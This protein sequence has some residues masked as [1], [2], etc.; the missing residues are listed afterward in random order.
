MTQALDMS[1]IHEISESLMRISRLLH[2]HTHKLEVAVEGTYAGQT[3]DPRVSLLMDALLV[4]RKADLELGRNSQA[5]KRLTTQQLSTS[6]GKGNTAATRAVFER[7]RAELQSNITFLK[8]QRD[9]QGILADIA[10]TLNSTLEFD[11]VLRLVMDRVIEFV[12]AERGF[13][14]LVDQQTQDLEF[15]IARDKQ[16]RTIPESEF[17]TAG[18]SRG[19]VKRTITTL[20]PLVSDDA[21]LDASLNGHESIMTFGIRSMMCAPLVV[22]DHCIGAVYVDSRINANLF[23]QQHLDLLVA[24]C[25]QAAIAIDN[26]R[27]FADLNRAIQQV[28]DDKQYMD[29]IFASIA[30]GV[31]TID[32]RGY[33]TTFNASAGLILQINNSQAIGRHYTEAFASHAHIGVV[34][35]LRNALEHAEL[36]AHGTFVPSSVDNCIIPNRLNGPFSLNL[37]VSS[38]RDTQGAHIGAALVIDDRTE[39]KRSEAETKKIRGIFERYVHPNVVKQLI[40]DKNALNLGGETKEISVLFADIRGFTRLSESMPPEAVMDMI[41]RYMRIM[42]E[43]IW[44]EE[45]TITAFLGDAVMAIFNAPLPQEQHALRAVRAAWKMRMAVQ[46]YQQTHPQERFISFGIGVNTGLATVGNIGSQER[47]Q[48]YTAI[49]DVVN[50][51]SRLQNN[52]SDNDI[53]LNDTTYQQVYPYVRTGQPF[54]L[55]VK[56]KATPLTVRYLLGPL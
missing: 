16:A 40:R 22:R 41:N 36:H 25:N 8:K 33:V 53:L 51:A 19:V 54:Q 23:S 30:N 52:V 18:I 21:K 47:M 24:F 34:D 28:Q 13:L 29:N 49:G 32:S 12:S 11:E 27:L 20:E 14:M 10:R 46:G 7:E 9:E 50:V 37:Y 38:L 48:N 2:E 42:C 35:L 1:N 39:I 43:A 44:E 5:L 6:S 15:K 56:N 31:V 17:M 3:G 26:A 55:S 45:G 4:A